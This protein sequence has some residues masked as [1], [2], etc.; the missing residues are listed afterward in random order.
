MDTH[1]PGGG[2]FGHPS[3]PPALQGCW[4]ENAGFRS[5]R[6]RVRV[7]SLRLVVKLVEAM[8]AVRSCPRHAL[9]KPYADISRG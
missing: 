6:M 1:Q 4:V 5:A 8:L 7:T 3:H 9:G 2:Q